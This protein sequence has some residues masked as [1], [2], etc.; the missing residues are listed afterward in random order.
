MPPG[1]KTR[2]K[3]GGIDPAIVFPS[4]SQFMHQTQLPTI[5]SVL[6][7]LQSLT[8]G[9]VAQ[10]QHDVAI[11][12]VSKLVY[13]KWY[14]DTVYC[15]SLS[16]VVRLVQDMWHKFRE[17]RKR[18]A[19]GRQDGKAI[20]QYKEL[21]ENANKL[22]DIGATTMKQRQSCHDDWGVSMTDQEERYYT[23]Q[24]TT[25]LMECNKSV[26]PVWYWAMMRKERLKSRQEEYKKQRKEQFQFKNL[27]QITKILTEEFGGPMSS[28][29]SEVSPVSPVKTRSSDCTP[30]S[31]KKRKWFAGA[32]MDSDE[33]MF[34][35]S[36]AHVRD[37]ERKVKD[38]LYLTISALSG[39]G[40]SLA[41]SCYA[42]LEVANNMFDRQWKLPDCDSDT[43]DLDTL[44]DV[45]NIRSAT[46]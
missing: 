11:R 40:M 6:G 14:H 16:A 44:P 1:T 8:G 24:Q 9:G 2:S 25:R 10:V 4:M 43:F 45:R 5:K 18:F 21:V 29:S 20:S 27:E 13:A 46:Y 17:V 22:F 30:V 31:S 28:T 36:M 19:A 33:N 37:S 35:S 42:V 15:I 39:H 41:E 23:D 32:D 34:P 7:V 12:E 3:S 26:D 38:S